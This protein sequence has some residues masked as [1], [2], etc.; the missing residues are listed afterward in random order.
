MRH[1]ESLIQQSIV[2]YFNL[3]HS[4]GIIA[5][6]P[7]GGAR[8]PKTG[9]KLKKEGLLAGIPDLIVILQGKVIFVEVKTSV[10]RLSTSQKEIHKKMSGLGFEVVVVR[11]LEE[12]I[13]TIN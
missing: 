6:I 13:S 5:M 12:F 10:G 7:N 1:E 11:S 8:N 9:A 2:Q 4:E 3:K